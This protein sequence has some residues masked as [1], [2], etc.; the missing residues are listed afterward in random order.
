[1]AESTKR[2]NI[3][4]QRCPAVGMKQEPKHR[5]VYSL[6]YVSAIIELL[7]YENI[8]KYL[9]FWTLNVFHMIQYS[10]FV[11]HYSLV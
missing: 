1:M 5:T 6:L 8:N 3:T 7:N 2:P 10:A 4:S 9:R 11:S